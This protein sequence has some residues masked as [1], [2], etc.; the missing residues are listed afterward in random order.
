[1]HQPPPLVLAPLL[2]LGLSPLLALAPV[3]ALAPILGL[4]EGVLELVAIA[5]LL[6]GRDDVLQLEPVQAPDPPQRLVDL[7]LLDLQ[8]ALVGEHLPGDAGMVSTRRNPL[9][10]RLQQLQRAR[11]RIAALALVHDGAHTI[12]GDRVG[13]KHDVA[14]LAEARHS[15]APE[16]ERLDPQLQHLAALGTA[17]AISS[18]QHAHAHGFDTNSSSSA[19]C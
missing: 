18:L 3:L 16:C 5:P 15:L 11:V 9:R 2:I 10:A 13:D 14:A 8:L 6:D 19:F 1:A 4:T 7:V 12:A 17:R